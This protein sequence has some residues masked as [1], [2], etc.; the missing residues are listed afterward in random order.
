M[1]LSVN[2]I[3]TALKALLLLNEQAEEIEKV[4]RMEF[5]LDNKRKDQIIK[6]GDK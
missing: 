3:Y 6:E 4:D 1:R 2:E 5:V